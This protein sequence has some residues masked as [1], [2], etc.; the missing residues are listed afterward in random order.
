M[1]VG[2][3]V[4]PD[5]FGLAED[6][7]SVRTY[8]DKGR[9][10]WVFQVW[11]RGGR[12][13]RKR[14][15]DSK[16]EAELALV[17]FI[18]RLPRDRS[19]VMKRRKLEG[20]L[21]DFYDTLDVR[22]STAKNY[23]N[24]IAS[25]VEWAVDLEPSEITSS[26]VMKYIEHLR[27]KGL[28]SNSIASIVSPLRTAW[29]RALRLSEGPEGSAYGV[30][31]N[32]WTDL[33]HYGVRRPRGRTQHLSEGQVEKVIEAA[34]V[35]SP[36]IAAVVGTLIFSGLRSAELRSLTWDD[37]DLVGGRHGLI[38]V[39]NGKGGK[40][41]TVPISRRLRG[42]LDAYRAD[43]RERG[44]SNSGPVFRKVSRKLG[45]NGASSYWRESLEAAGI[46]FMPLHCSRHT[47]ASLWV[48]SGVDLRTVMAWLGH[49]SLSMV[50]I[51][52][53]MAPDRDAQVDKVDDY[54]S[55]LTE[56][57]SENPDE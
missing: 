49:S 18:S 7:T 8:M 27:A 45:R 9:D 57:N 19:E 36:M 17:R 40:D 12:R 39:R 6:V 51:Y 21:Q 1:A 43:R 56:E 24:A 54:L 48:R 32:P 25:F 22:P 53:H 34:T 44:L 14:G 28:T 16:R 4:P 31:S 5:D 47:A 41:R 26:V 10:Y 46:S 2:T 35:K 33:K 11:F 13:V 55:R 23:R 30:T 37:V 52:A 38:H 29:N 15:G 42:I 3:T 50:S 20:L